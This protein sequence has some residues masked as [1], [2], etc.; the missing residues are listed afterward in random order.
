MDT[1]SF[2][3]SGKQIFLALTL[4]I[5]ISFATVY[6]G[7]AAKGPDTLKVAINDNGSEIIFESKSETVGDFLKNNNIPVRKEDIL[8]PGREKLLDKSKL[9]SITILRAAKVTLKDGL[10]VKTYYTQKETVEEFLKEQ[11]I[12]LSANDLILDTSLG[13][14]IY[15]EMTISIVRIEEDLI[16]VSEPI[17]FETV[18]KPN[19]RLDQGIEKVAREGRE[20]IKEYVYRIAMENGE[21]ISRDLVETKIVSEPVQRVVEYGTIAQ[22]T[23]SRGDTLRYEKVLDMRA[24]AYTASYE[25]TGKSPGHPQFGITY[26]GVKAEVGIVAVDPTVIP[27]GSRLYIEGIGNT[28]DYGFALAADIGSAVK[29]DVIDLY[30]DSMEEAYNW[31]VKKVKVYVLTD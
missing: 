9:N 25:C 21:V 7:A 13:S 5:T 31:G 26:T 10:D 23:I 19:Q 15:P 8:I 2:K 16:F 12:T 18:R 6:F 28:P 4:I 30:V 29:G 11:D 22:K 20:G 1:E 14:L 24:T 3:F 27:L 17:A